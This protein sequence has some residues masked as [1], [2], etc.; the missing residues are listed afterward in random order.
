MRKLRGILPYVR[1]DISCCLLTK[2]KLQDNTEC[3]SIKINVRKKKWLLCCSYNPNKNNI[4]NHLHCLSKG[5]DTYIRQYDNITLM[6]DLN[7]ESLDPVL[8]N[9]CNVYNLFSFAKEPISFKNPY[10][11]PCIE[12]SFVNGPRNVHC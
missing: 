12:L 7:V 3:L 5:L 8:N 10:N 9:F 1:D 6:G 4:P 11:P 2:Y